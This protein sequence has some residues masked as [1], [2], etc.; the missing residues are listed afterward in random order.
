[1]RTSAMSCSVKVNIKTELTIQAGSVGAL[2]SWVTNSFLISSNLVNMQGKNGEKRELNK[3][4]GSAFVSDMLRHVL[5]N[6]E[7]EIR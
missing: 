4:T 1:M 7:Q 3:A 2:L 5:R 6:K